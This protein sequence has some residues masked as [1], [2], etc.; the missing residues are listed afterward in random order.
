MRTMLT[1]ATSILSLMLA[2]PCANADKKDDAGK[3]AQT[4]AKLAGTW[5]AKKDGGTFLV[6]ISKDGKLK[7]TAKDK[8]GNTIAEGEGTFEVKG[9]KVMSV[10][11]IKGEEKKSTVTIKSLTEKTMVIVEGGQTFEYKR[12]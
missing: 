6:V 5:E 8:D 11:K 10:T 2:V 12:K 7:F 3:D 1:V 4:M 9:D